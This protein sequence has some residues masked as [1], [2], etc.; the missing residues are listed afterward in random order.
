MPV[1]QL[2][3]Q[4]AAQ[5]VA[6]ELI[7]NQD[8]L[9]LLKNL[10]RTSISTIC[11]FRGLLPPECFEECTVAGLHISM[12][13]PNAHPDID[14]LNSWLQD[15]VF[16]ALKKNYLRKVVLGIYTRTDPEKL[17]ESYTFRVTLVHGQPT[18]TL[19][20]DT[21]E[22]SQEEPQVDPRTRAKDA[23]VTMLRSLIGQTQ[24]MAPLGLKEWRM[25]MKIYY[26]RG[27]VPDGYT[28]QN[29]V[30]SRSKSDDEFDFDHISVGDID[31]PYHDMTVTVAR[32]GDKASD[33]KAS[34]RRGKGT[35]AKAKSVPKAGKSR[36]VKRVG[37]R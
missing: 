36:S 22:K 4:K 16:D 8:S 18:L 2:V 35:T 19:G 32:A 6:N 13:V 31:T 9:T 17:V 28:P 12:L 26:I 5:S 29:F 34:G 20:S 33:V 25:R 14:K 23:T 27:A 15:G 11:H 1:A 37:R 24:E 7:T 30:S 3:R 21:Q 10:F